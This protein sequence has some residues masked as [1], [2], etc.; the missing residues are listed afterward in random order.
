MIKAI[1]FALD[2]VL[3][4]ATEWHY[5][6]LNEALAEFGYTI[7]RKEHLSRYNGLPTKTKLKMLNNEKGMPKEYNHLICDLKQ[8]FTYAIIQKRCKP[9]AEK[10]YMMN[11]LYTHH[12][13]A[14]CS[15]A[16][17]KSVETMLRKS[18]LIEYCEFFLSNEDVDKPKPDPEIYDKA[19]AMLKLKPEECLIVE[20]APS[21]IKAARASGA[22]VLEVK[23]FDDV[24]YER[25]AGELRKIDG[26]SR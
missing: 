8:Q 25:I 18:E 11:M 22:H 26:D 15:N 24:N 16:I 13:I 23:G 6:A 3:I 2:G 14:V 5:E 10:G 1:I 7:T 17:R 9:D 4:D 12:K 19:I 20:D 21:G